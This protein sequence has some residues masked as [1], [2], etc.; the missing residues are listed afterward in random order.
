MT[1]RECR[2]T[3]GL[4]DRLVS[5]RPTD[6]D[7]AH[8]P[9][10]PS[11]G[12]VLA[13][14]ATFD[15][16]LRRTARRLVVEDLPRGILDPALALRAGGAPRSPSLAP[17]FGVAGVAVAIV[18][19]ATAVALGPGST[20][21]NG[22]PTA[23]PGGSAGGSPGPS[24]GPATGPSTGPST[25]APTGPATGPVP[26]GPLNSTAR[27][28]SAVT[29]LAYSCREGQP[30][31]TSGTSAGTAVR[32]G[33]VCSALDGSG[34]FVATIIAG[35]SATG[36]VVYVSIKG[37]LVGSDT[38]SSREALGLALARLVM[39]SFAEKELGIAASNDVLA[40]F[41]ELEPGAPEL[42]SQFGA[43]R[44][45]MERHLDGNYLLTVEPFPPT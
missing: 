37:D 12:P 5:D 38:P 22:S 24:T 18:L 1:E 44:V 39:V 36:E 4:L 28:V 13:R 29:E 23:S 41:G 19:L 40:R 33:A 9:G 17:G 35:E 30:L 2:R 26:R 21:P 3:R 10:C 16:E 8:A 20:D 14:S 43:G 27:I 34:P 32:E 25:G 15:D 7:L 11:C 6:D 42:T 45:R 31:A